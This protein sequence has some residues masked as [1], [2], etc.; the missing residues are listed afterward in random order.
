MHADGSEAADPT[1][2]RG[3]LLERGGRIALAVGVVPWWRVLSSR[4]ATDPRVRALAKEL[5]GTVVGQGDPLY[6]QARLL[7][8]TRFD[9]VKPLAVAY[10]ES[11]TDV[12]KSIL[13][14]RR[15]GI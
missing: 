5:Q 2:D 9:S 12:A 10:C 1:L 4:A 3:E 15:H 13:W 8:S 11:A 7:Y 14:S 6:D